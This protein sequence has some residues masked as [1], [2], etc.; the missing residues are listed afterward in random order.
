MGGCV[1]VVIEKG[2]RDRTPAQEKNKRKVQR[3]FREGPEKGGESSV[4]VGRSVG[5]HHREW[6]ERSV[7]NESEG[8]SEE[9]SVAGN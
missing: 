7:R 9:S 3:R 6:W 8:I 4:I 1:C 2:T 5:D